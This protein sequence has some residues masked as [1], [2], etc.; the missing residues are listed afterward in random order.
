MKTRVLGFHA[1]YGCRSAGACCTSGWTIAAEPEAE[2]GWRRAWHEGRLR[3]DGARGLHDLVRPAPGLPE[4]ARVA[5]RVDGHGRCA[6]FEPARG[7]LC[8]LHRQLG[9]GALPVACRQ[10]PRVA[11]LTPGATCLTLSHYCPTAADLLFADTDGAILD[12]PPAFPGDG[13]YEGLDAR[14]ALPPLLRPGVLMGW[15]GHALWEAHA[16]AEL[17]GPGASPAEA[18][19]RLEA[20]AEAARGWRTEDG[21]FAAHLTSVLRPGAVQASA[22]G[23][24]SFAAEVDRWRTVRSCVPAGV[25]APAEPGGDA[26]DADRR[27]VTP[28]WREWHG[29]VGRYLAAR[30]FA[31][32]CALQGDGLRTTVSAVRH[33]A[34]VLRVEA[35]RACAAAGRALDA[36]LLKEAL[37]A[38]DLLL[39][40]L[41]S[42]EALA[43]RLSRCEEAPG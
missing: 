35:A 5:L 14:K 10:F 6:F 26:E 32:W 21:P 38:A 2:D 17:A 20:Q 37:R 29:P 1:R 11:L 7:H 13:E 15:D 25:A 27:W 36:I 40:H 39:V 23:D 22:G 19:A 8:G 31:S 41:A 30:A 16:V 28:A 3:V 12:D 4:G 33:A 9:Q 34:S 42:P 18:L 24:A 43:R